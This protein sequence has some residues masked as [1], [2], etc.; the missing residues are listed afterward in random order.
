LRIGIFVCFCGSNIGGTVDVEKV[1]SEALKFPGVV[2]TQTNLYTCSEPGQAQIINAVKEHKLNRV[3]VASCSPRV[4]QGTFMRTVESVG[5]NPYLFDMANIR[6]HVS[7]IHDDKEKA[8]EKA[9]E[10]IRM[11]AAKVYRHNELFP[12]FFDVN[13]KVIIVGGGIAGIQAALDI[14]EGGRKVVLV[15]RESSIGGKMAQLD[16][17]FPTIDCSACI[18]SPK[19]VDVGIHE[20]IELLTLSEVL[21][22]EGSI[23]NFQVTIKKKPRYINEKNCTACGECEKVCPVNIVNEYEAGLS[24]R[25]AI[26]RMFTQAVPSAYNINFK[27]KA[28]CRSTCPANVPAQG[29]IALIREGKYME[30]LKLHREENPFPSICGRACM[31][32]CEESCTRNLVDDPIAIMGLKRFMADYEL[33]LGEIPLPEMEEKKDKKVAVIGSGPAGLTAAY[34][35]AKKGYGVKIFESLPVTGGMLRVGI[36]RYRLPAEIIDLEIDVVKR[37]GVQIET[38]HPIEDYDQVYNLKEKEGFEAVFLATGAHQD[39]KLNCEGEDLK[40]VIPGITFLRDAALSKI[41]KL[42]GKVAVIGGGNVAIDSARTALRLGAKEVSIFYRRSRDEMPALEEEVE[43]TLEEGIKINYLTA[44][45]KIEGEK[46]RSRKLVLIKNELGEPDSSGRRRPVPIQG[47]EY[48]YPVDHIIVTIGQNP[49]IGYLQ[50]GQRTCQ[51]TSWS[52]V[53]LSRE[54]ILAV[55]DNGI[56]A[57]GDLVLGPATLTEAIGH[58]KRAADAISRMLEGESLDDIEKDIKEKEE[59]TIKLKPEEVFTEKQLKTFQRAK[60]AVPEKVSP[61]ERIKNFDEIV[62]PFEE[63]QAKAEAERCLNCGV[64]SECHE[65]IKAC[66]ANCIDYDQKEEIITLEAGAIIAATG[67]EEYDPESYGEYGGGQLEDVITGLK[68]ERLMCASGPTG[69]HILRPSDNKE[70]KKIV[71]LSCVGSRDITKGMP[72]CSGACC[73]YIAKQAILTKEHIPDSQ[74]YVFYT[75]VRS[76]GKDYDEFIMRAKQYGTQ[77]IRGKVSKIYKK[78]DKLIIRGSDTILGEAIEMEAD[79]VVMASAMIPSKGSRKLAEVLNISTGPFG[80]YTESHP[81]L[82]PVETNTSGIY[83][84]GAC[85]SP[86]D[87]PAS[88]AQ[89]SAAAAKVLA[90]FSKDKLATDPIVARVD[91]SRCVG[92]NKCIMVCPFSAI[93]EVDIRGKNVAQVIESVCKGCGLCEAT[94][95]IDAISLSFF[96]DEMI[97]QELDSIIY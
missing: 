60:R 37:M 33:R 11:A 83:L 1:A 94:C 32:P 5:L 88:V 56:F 19:M 4:H 70:P 25:K 35:L 72:Y 17:T 93:E 66:E 95:P 75:D 80:F 68:Y 81:K 55:D 3:I 48:D 14:A 38:N 42:D 24:T 79:M 62:K 15:E 71:F 65:C 18:L 77:Y 22:V 61:E 30:A 46:G 28:P 96:T 43:E 13:K 23:G 21:N 26:S 97:L 89:G 34:F 53:Q 45:V 52:T 36:P 31:H 67:F 2:F 10:L 8:T 49:D 44:P 12:K 16:K 58:G 59:N 47:S 82:R 39:K 29:Y 74:S 6:E 20:N 51:L 85:Q 73:M 27:G 54:T 86:K 69:G 63:P 91:Q 9:I 64:C 90:L 50:G 41:K 84:A 40:G 87:I 7:W 57:G 78:G 76:P 92:C